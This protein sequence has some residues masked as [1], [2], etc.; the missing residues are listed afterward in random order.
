MFSGVLFLIQTE[1]IYS[2]SLYIVMNMQISYAIFTY[3]NQLTV[4]KGQEGQ[5]ASLD[6]NHLINPQS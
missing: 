5:Q 1:P 4:S 3:R 6:Y 2:N